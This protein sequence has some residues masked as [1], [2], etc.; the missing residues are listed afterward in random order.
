[1]GLVS[2]LDENQLFSDTELNQKYNHYWLNLLDVHNTPLP[3]N[4]KVDFSC[5]IQI[6]QQNITLYFKFPDLLMPESHFYDH[7]PEVPLSFFKRYGRVSTVN[8]SQKS[9]SKGDLLSCYF[10]INDS[11]LLLIDGNHRYHRSIG[12]PDMPKIRFIPE[13]L[14]IS[15]NCFSDSNSLYWYIFLVE[16]NTIQRIKKELKLTD[17]EIWNKLYCNTNELYFTYNKLF[18]GGYDEA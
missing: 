1:M 17:A 8:P 14:L 7:L 12:G 10:P 6:S 16:L 11:L 18:N 13:S 5:T 4:I 2:F 15:N 9:Q 3:H